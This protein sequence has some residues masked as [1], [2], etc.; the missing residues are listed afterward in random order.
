MTSSN[1]NDTNYQQKAQDYLELLR[2]YR[3]VENDMRAFNDE[4][5]NQFRKQ[6][7][8]TQK[9]EVENYKLLEDL[10]IQD[11]H[12]NKQKK[13]QNAAQK[14]IEAQLEEIEKIKERCER[15]T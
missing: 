7:E 6:Q 11:T 13:E 15:E 12:A 9:F 8:K 5:A 2:K 14:D 3:Q 10:Q 4:L 1:Q